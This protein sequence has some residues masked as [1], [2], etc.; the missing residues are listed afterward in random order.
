MNWEATKKL[1]LDLLGMFE[2][3]V[4][5]THECCHTQ[6][7]MFY[8]CS[9]RQNL[10]D[11]FMDYLWKKVKNPNEYQVNRRAAV[12]YLASFIV[13]AQYVSTRYVRTKPEQDISESEF[14][15]NLVAGK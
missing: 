7:L 13:R 2:K 10:A 5:P 1:Y 8:I 9:L 6:Y 3:V 4:L 11:G 15:V 14:Y 12:C